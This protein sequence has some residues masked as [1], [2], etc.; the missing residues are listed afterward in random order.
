[1]R[2]VLEPSAIAARARELPKLLKPLLPVGQ[3]LQCWPQSTGQFILLSPYSG[4]VPSETGIEGHK[5][6]TTVPRIRAAYQ[7]RWQATDFEKKSYAMERAYL[8]I[9]ERDSNGI[10]EQIVA[11]HCDPNES[12]TAKHYK[13]KAGPHIHMMT[14]RDPLPHAHIGLN[15]SELETVL[16]S[17]KNL[18]VAISSAIALVQTQILGLY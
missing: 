7:E 14:A 13:Y 17:A 16:K 2:C 18:T 8:H 11:L 5:F 6:A 15:N 3:G 1:M 12:Q 9:Y 4:P 10:E